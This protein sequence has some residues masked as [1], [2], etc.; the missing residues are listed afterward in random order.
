M[1][2]R[3]FYDGWPQYNRRITEII[4]PVTDQQLAI[5]PSPEHLPMWAI[6][7]HMAGVRVY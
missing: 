1:S 3:L 5:R 7:G 4:A 2:I 6:V